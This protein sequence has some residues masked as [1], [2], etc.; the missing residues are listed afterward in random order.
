MRKFYQVIIELGQK[1]LIET[2][3]NIL[4][5]YIKIVASPD[6]FKSKLKLLQVNKAYY[7]VLRGIFKRQ[8]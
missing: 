7:K 8:I 3:R 2:Y 1:R 5:D 6:V 4:P